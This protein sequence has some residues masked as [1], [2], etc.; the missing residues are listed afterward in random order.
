MKGF[1]LHQAVMVDQVINHLILNKQ[2]NYVDCTF[3]LGGHTS[4]ILDNLGT[5]GFLT[6]IDRDSASTEIAIKISLE[7]KRMRFINDS[8]GNLESHCERNSLDGVLLDLGISSNQLDDPKRG[9]SFRN[10]G[11]LDMRMDQKSF[12]S[13]EF[14]LNNSSKEEIE[15]VL[16]QIGEERQSRK[17]ASLICSTRLKRPIQTTK[18][19]SDIILSCKGTASIKHPATNIFRA[20]RMKINSEIEELH[21]VLK[22]VGRVLKIGGRLA[23]ISFHSLEDRVAKR[24]IQGKDGAGFD[25]TFKLV[26][27]KPIK[28]D[29]SEIDDN[30]RSR[31]AILRIA[32]RIT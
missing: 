23:V 26:G 5:Q 24:F 29:K 18:E 13:A 10:S 25:S 7:D 31:S 9:F 8:F 32:E 30:P 2:G 20:I 6:S 21:S 4:A 19:L 15:K 14:W 22:A 11:P 3:G 17:I 28:P 16:R 27:G 1:E 12:L